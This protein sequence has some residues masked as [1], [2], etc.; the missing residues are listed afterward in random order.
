MLVLFDIAEKIKPVLQDVTQ[1]LQE[2]FGHKAVLLSGTYNDT[3]Y[4][5]D[6]YEDKILVNRKPATDDDVHTHY[7]VEEVLKYITNG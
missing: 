5:I 2:F 3:K 7:T 6:I 1:E 4:W